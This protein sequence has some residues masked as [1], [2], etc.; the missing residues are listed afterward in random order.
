MVRTLEALRRYFA[1]GRVDQVGR[2]LTN[3]TYPHYATYLT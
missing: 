1:D 2:Y 3:P